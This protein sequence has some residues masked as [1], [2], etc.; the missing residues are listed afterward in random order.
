MENQASIIGRDKQVPFPF[1][2]R[3][4]NYY[5]STAESRVLSS[6]LLFVGYLR[7][8][9]RAGWVKGMVLLLISGRKDED[10]GEYDIDLGN[11]CGNRGEG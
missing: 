2:H 5:L 3:I 1:E 4:I 6:S 11:R 10:A 7:S 8:R 9:L